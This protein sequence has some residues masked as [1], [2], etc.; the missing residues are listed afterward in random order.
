MGENKI[1]Q[2]L[3]YSN[4]CRYSSETFLSLLSVNNLFFATETLEFF[5]EKLIAKLSFLQSEETENIL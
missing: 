4:S 2:C 1:F 3:L 5:V